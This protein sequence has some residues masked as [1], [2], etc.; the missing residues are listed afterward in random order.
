MEIVDCSGQVGEYA[1]LALD[2]NDKAHISYWDRTSQNL[3]YATN[4][5]GRWKR[6]VV[7][8]SGNVGAFTSIAVD[9]FGAPHISY[10]TWDTQDLRYARFADGIWIILTVDE[11]GNVGQYSSL[12]L[13][14][15]DKAHISY[16][17]ATNGDLK[18]A[19]N[20]GGWFVP[21][22]VDSAGNVG[23]Y[24]SLAL[25]ADGLAHIS[26]YDATNGDLEYARR[27]VSD[28]Q[29]ETV[30]SE[31]DVGKHT[32]LALD[33]SGVAHISYVDVSY[34]NLKYAAKEG[35]A[36]S[37]SPLDLVGTSGGYTSIALDSRG[38]AHISYF[39]A[40]DLKL[41]Y[42]SQEGGSWSMMNIESRVGYHTSLELDRDDRAHIGYC[43]GDLYL[44][45]AT[46]NVW[47]QET[48]ASTG[49]SGEHSS[50]SLDQRGRVH[51]A[52]YDGWDFRFKYA[53]NALGHWTEEIVDY[54]DV[55]LHPSLAIDVHGAV[56]ISYWDQS[57]H[58]LKYANNSGG[59]WSPV[60]VDDISNVVGESSLAL[61]AGGMAHISYYAEDGGNLMHATNAGGGWSTSVID[62]SVADTGRY[63]SLDIDPAG[64]LHVSYYDVS[65]LDLRYATNRTGAWVAQVL[66]SAGDVGRYS[67]LDVDSGGYV[68]IGYYDATNGDLRY[69]TDAL[70]GWTQLPVVTDGDVGSGS[71]LEVDPSDRVHI[72]YM[73]ATLGAVKYASNA[74]GVWS[75]TT[76]DHVG[77]NG[78]TSL[79]LDNA[80]RA[81]I[82]YH[83][84]SDGSL[85][86]ITNAPWRLEMVD[87]YGIS[88]YYSSMALDGQGN[89]HIAYLYI[90]E[91]LS[92]RNLRYATNAGGDWDITVVDRA[93]KVGWRPSLALDADGRAHISYYDHDNTA[94]KYATNAGGSWTNRTVDESGD[95]G[96][97]S[98]IAVDA[99]GKVHIGYYDGSGLRYAENTLGTWTIGTL[100]AQSGQYC[101]IALDGEEKVHLS[102][103]DFEGKLGYATNA[104]GYW[105]FQQ[106]DPS[107]YGSVQETSLALDPLGWV[108]IAYMGYSGG[109]STG[110]PV[111]VTNV[112]GEWNIGAV[113]PK[114]GASSISLALDPAGKPYISYHHRD[115][116]S[117]RLATRN[118]ENLDNPFGAWDIG[119]VDRMG[120]LEDPITTSLD[121][122]QDGKPHIS[123][124]NSDRGDLR[125]AMLLSEPSAPTLQVSR[126]ID[127]WVHLEWS[128]PLRDHGFPVQYYKAFRGTTPDAMQPITSGNTLETADEVPGLGTYYYR[129]AAVNAVG[130]GI[131]SEAVRID[132]LT[133][134]G[135]PTGAGV[136]VEGSNYLHMAW[137]APTEDGGSPVESYRVY[138]GPSA[139]G[140]FELAGTTP[141]QSTTIINLMNGMTY[142]FKVSAVNAAGEGP[143]S[144]VFSG[145][146]R[147]AAY[148][149]QNLTA[150]A[151]AAGVTLS[152]EPPIS[153]GGGYFG[154][155]HI[156]RGTAP[157]GETFLDYVTYDK[158]SFLDADVDPGLAYYYKVAVS[159][160]YGLGEFSDQ[161]WAIAADV[162]D[163]PSWLI[164]HSGNGM[165]YL[166]W[167][168]PQ[169]N[170]ADIDHYVIYRNGTDIAHTA[171]LNFTDQGLLNGVAYTYTVAARNGVG[172]G[173]LSYPVMVVPKT[174][175]G[176]PTG[177]TA[178]RGNGLVALTWS[179]PL[180]DGGSDVLRYNVYRD[181]TL[182]GTSIG[183][184]YND[185]GLSNGVL[186][187][188]AV[189]AVNS[190]GEGPGSQV[191]LVMP[192]AV[193][194]APAGLL[195]EAGELQIAL[196][197]SVPWFTGEGTLT[198]HLFR[199]GAEVWN[200]TGTNHLDTGLVKGRSYSYAVAASN[201]AGRGEN[202]TAVQ[203]TALGVPD[204]PTGLTALAL[205]GTMVL[206]WGAP[207]YT[208]PGTLVYHV[209]RDEHE[210]WNGTETNCI[211]DAPLEPGVIYQYTIAASN[212][213]GWGENGTAAQVEAVGVPDPPTGL[214][215]EGLAGG[216]SLSWNA[217]IYTG[218]GTLIYHVFR[219]GEEVWTGTSAYYT[220]GGTLTSGQSYEYTVSASNSIGWGEN[221]TAAA[222]APLAPDLDGQDLPILTILLVMVIVVLVA[223]LAVLFLRRG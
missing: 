101:S 173:P 168:A 163:A 171:F 78:L 22:T 118:G 151:D 114:S 112:E 110:K 27:T 117:L 80:G 134:P 145:M 49:F 96:W 199:D 159:N 46:E 103:R 33:H 72:S 185:T 165:A 128:P 162:P 3:V 154:T 82:S 17:D 73:D 140:A 108:H 113:D 66:D 124:W 192:Q 166:L 195:A 84:S 180:D 205:H 137:S 71:S 107:S 45:Y 53:T 167:R 181:G 223:L 102:Y 187:E 70:G 164:G 179:A 120:Y 214:Q 186:Y 54:Y 11:T 2:A 51:I 79:A 4:A 86:Y 24:S 89:A 13:D 158:F 21:G 25:D 169:D 216:V 212:L 206:M 217:P 87:D 28:W 75:V 175:P 131:M 61:D 211:D 77:T 150:Q 170:G 35:V 127:L 147:G 83:D 18:Y 38:E 34:G 5:D 174:V 30:D 36:W 153:Y 85:C 68:H 23:Q 133:P 116:M 122:D 204:P 139:T 197:W 194:D 100:Q 20:A 178:E 222:A 142:Y 31:W 196:T 129:V 29:F 191:Q 190:A 12:A 160:E 91:D 62:S 19:T 121:L 9:A 47:Y 126:A 50:I 218:P 210:V 7:D 81:H 57:N 97:Y 111:Y 88:G 39:D 203:A 201:P 16:Y 155:T 189:S 63:S 138:Q 132:V 92:E 193:P 208:G 177:L 157:G 43:D 56:H 104:L 6:S 69:V 42:A 146:P 136:D 176:V 220:D 26:Y 65:S 207:D 95:S 10:H 41:R 37:T 64:H 200:G 98:S 152:W 215:A 219:N 94:L 59:S 172:T 130:M 52:Y 60:V 99:N 1:S 48:V 123:Y 198:Y 184:S 188:Y 149:P 209:F 105:L 115:D 202:S 58:W 14:A 161:A 141:V 156:Y 74:S 8:D 135:A 109:I 182:L 125:Y 93:G 143:L 106:I 119:S 44:K 213:L 76:V 55:G 90:S 148:A 144:S 67:S 40:L 183:T 15:D 221:S 32:S